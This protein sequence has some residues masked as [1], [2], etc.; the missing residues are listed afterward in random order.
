VAERFGL[1][2]E[3]THELESGEHAAHH[4]STREWLDGVS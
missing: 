3:L 2:S 1:L 4:T